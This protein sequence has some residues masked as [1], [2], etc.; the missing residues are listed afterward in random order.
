MTLQEIEDAVAGN[1]M[2]P[3]QVFTQMKQHCYHEKEPAKTEVKAY[4]ATDWFCIEGQ[5]YVAQVEIE[6]EKKL[7]G[8]GE[9]IEIDGNEYYVSNAER[10]LKPMSPPIPSKNVGI[11]I[12]GE[13]K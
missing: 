2:T 4:K 3:A 13:R 11:E 5:G 9:L 10:F 8:K 12:C 7:P 1:E 6:L